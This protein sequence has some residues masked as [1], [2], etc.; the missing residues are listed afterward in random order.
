MGMQWLLLEIFVQKVFKTNLNKDTFIR[1]ILKIDI[2]V[3]PLDNLLSK[4]VRKKPNR[5]HKFRRVWN[6]TDTILS[7]TRIGG[8]KIPSVADE[9]FG[10][11]HK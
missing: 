5:P 8:G 2:K 6:C 4:R 1:S 11:I 3:V 9:G 10:N 7:L